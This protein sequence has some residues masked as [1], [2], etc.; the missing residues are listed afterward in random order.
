MRLPFCTGVT[1]SGG[2]KARIS[3]ARAAYSQEDIVLLD[4][5]LSALD[6]HTGRHVFDEV[7]AAGGIMQNSARV[8]VTHAGVW[9]GFGLGMVRVAA[10]PCDALC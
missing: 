8:L 4:D 1:L 6:A 7:F 10:K 9:V 3:V 5:P 2:Q